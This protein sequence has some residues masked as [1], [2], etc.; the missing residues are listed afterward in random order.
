LRVKTISSWLTVQSW[1][2]QNRRK[3]VLGFPAHAKFDDCVLKMY[4]VYMKQ[5]KNNFSFGVLLLVLFTVFGVLLLQGA[6][7]NAATGSN[8]YTLKIGETIKITEYR[9][10]EITLKDL[11]GI[12]TLSYPTQ[13][14]NIATILIHISG[15]CPSNVSTSNAPCLGM[16][17]FQGE[18]KVSEGQTV[19]VLGLKI[20]VVLIDERNQ[21]IKIEVIVSSAEPAPTV[22][23]TLPPCPTTQGVMQPG[24][25]SRPCPVTPTPTPT[26]LP[27][28]ACLDATPRCLLAEPAG[29]WCQSPTPIPIPIG[30]VVGGGVIGICPLGSSNCSVCSGNQCYPKVI[31]GGTAGGIG[32]SGGKPAQTEPVKLTLSTNETIS[33]VGRTEASGNDSVYQVK[34]TKKAR[35][36]FLLPIKMGVTYSVNSKTG[37]TVKNQPWWDFLVW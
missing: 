37:Q 21:T 2:T 16:P 1:E 34:T 11:Q 28:P 25:A 30:G 3:A 13:V 26:C 8:Q 6:V 33:E 4:N 23:P 29:G 24:T 7:I 14:R 31:G 35:L 27:R 22:S 12:S 18:Y 19:V 10:A 15:G 17:D 5:I 36:L 20:K 32:V 9:S